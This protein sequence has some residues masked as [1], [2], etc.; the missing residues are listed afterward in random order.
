M[1][2]TERM[3]HLMT[4]K[5]SEGGA[6]RQGNRATVENYSPTALRYAVPAH[7]QEDALVDIKIVRALCGFNSSTPIYDRLREGTFV[8][9]IR[10]S[11]RCT[12]WRLRDVRR[13]LAAQGQRSD[14]SVAA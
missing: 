3:G 9:P 4:A 10:L 6:T 13:W 12:R 5:A 8:E 1:L 2:L 14:E 7:V 11:S